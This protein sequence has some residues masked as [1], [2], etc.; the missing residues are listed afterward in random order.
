MNL[1]PATF[2]RPLVWLAHKFGPVSFVVLFL[3]VMLV[4]IAPVLAIP[5]AYLARVLRTALVGARPTDERI[6]MR[7]QLPKIATSAPGAVLWLG[8]IGGAMVIGGSLAQ[9]IDAYVEGHLVRTASMTFLGLLG[10]A[11]LIAYFGYLLRLRAKQ[12][13]EAA[14]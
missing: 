12:R 8:L 5:Q 3:A 7:E 2:A 6:K 4:I 11:L 13:R 10:G 1:W 9:M 14:R